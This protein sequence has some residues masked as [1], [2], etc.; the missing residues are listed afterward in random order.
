MAKKPSAAPSELTY[1]LTMV[2]LQDLLPINA[3]LRSA[4]EE[5]MIS[6]LG[7]PELPL[8]TQ[9]QPDR[10]SSLVKALEVTTRISANIKPTGIRPAISSLGGILKDAFAQEAG[11][12]H[13]LEAVLDDDGMLVV[14]YRRPTNGHPST[15][16][17]N[18]SWGTAIDFRLVG[19]DPPGNTHGMVPRFVAV[20]LPFFNRA[21]WY[22]GIG[23]SDTMHFEVADDTIHKWAIE[24]ALKP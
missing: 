6:L 3:G 8:T 11:S 7:S 14:R 19:H 5:T 1:Y 20:L 23:F 22:S 12:G 4:Q 24:G 2:P 17:S 18:H 9:D 15:K 10:A 16:I 21:G 13:N